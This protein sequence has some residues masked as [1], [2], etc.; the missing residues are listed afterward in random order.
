M[1]FNL[2]VKPKAERDIRNPLNGTENNVEIYQRN[3]W[4]K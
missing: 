1:E 2:I 3:F 4:I